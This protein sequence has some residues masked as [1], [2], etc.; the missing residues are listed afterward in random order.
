MNNSKTEPDSNHNIEPELVRVCTDMIYV[1]LQVKNEDHQEEL[2]QNLEQYSKECGV[3]VFSKQG[4]KQVIQLMKE[5]QSKGINY[6]IDHKYPN[7]GYVHLQ[8]NT[9]ELDKP[10]AT[11]LSGDLKYLLGDRYPDFIR[12]STVTRLD[13]AA[14]FIN[15][16]MDDISI[17]NLRQRRSQAN[18]GQ[19]G[20]LQTLYIGHSKS[21]IMFRMYDK[22]AE[23]KA[24]S[25]SRSKGTVDADEPQVTRIEAS[26]NPKCSFNRIA[27]IDNPFEGLEIY[28]LSYLVADRR[29]PFSFSDSI[30]YR[31][32]TA[33]LKLLEPSERKAV[34]KLL[35]DHVYQDF[36]ADEIFQQWLQSLKTLN[37]L[38]VP[39]TKVS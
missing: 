26:I 39:K 17:K 11:S 34:K 2:R 4:Y 30:H 13:I 25:R 23:I 31:G 9:S 14:D 28:K 15:L 36:P 27:K 33:T 18:W 24:K 16:K 20:Q 37:P 6:C 38:K 12:K 1:N 10:M 7:R 5:E 22:T 32:L 3:P 19:N 29:L 8:G 21:D 35:D